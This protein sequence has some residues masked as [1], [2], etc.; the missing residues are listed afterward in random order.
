[1]MSQLLGVIC[2]HR[3]Y[4]CCPFICCKYDAD[5]ICWGCICLKVQVHIMIHDA[6]LSAYSIKDTEWRIAHL[7]LSVCVCVEFLHSPPQ[8]FLMSVV[9]SL[10]VAP[11]DHPR[12][13]Y[14]RVSKHL[15][16]QSQVLPDVL[17][18]CQTT[19]WH[20]CTCP[21]V[22]IVQGFHGQQSIEIR[23][24]HSPLLVHN[25]SC[26]ICSIRI[27]WVSHCISYSAAAVSS[28]T[29]CKLMLIKSNQTKEFLR[30]SRIWPSIY[31][32]IRSLIQ[33]RIKSI[34][35]HVNE[36]WRCTVL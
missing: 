33:T 35:G 24:M 36:R 7:L 16:Y 21:S 2:C 15:S 34:Y 30:I 28:P 1:M 3:H 31:Y 9:R 10:L 23:W 17:L 20:G 26:D 6:L 13:V 29:T 19:A 11:D 14:I 18:Q 8:L 12:V 25:C 27:N 32:S 22:C 5:L 4:G